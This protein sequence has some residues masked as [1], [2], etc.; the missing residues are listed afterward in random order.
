MSNQSH[1]DH[2]CLSPTDSDPELLEIKYR[3]A[4]QLVQDLKNLLRRRRQEAAMGPVAS[5]MPAAVA[6]RS[7]QLAQSPA[8]P[9]PSVRRSTDDAPNPSNMLGRDEGLQQ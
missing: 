7:G 2:R 1:R 6:S 4:M 5:S 8:L 3:N 9:G